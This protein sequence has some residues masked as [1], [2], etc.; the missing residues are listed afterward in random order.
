MLKAHLHGSSDYEIATLC[1]QLLSLVVLLLWLYSVYKCNCQIDSCIEQSLL[2]V[3]EL[4][5]GKCRL[6]CGEGH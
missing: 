1:W 2:W 4:A 6:V 3:S 5:S